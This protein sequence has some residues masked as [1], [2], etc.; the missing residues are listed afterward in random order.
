VKTSLKLIAFAP[1]VLWA[2]T[3]GV[4][5][6]SADAADFRK[7]VEKRLGK[8]SPI[9]K[10]ADICPVDTNV[11]AR[12]VF[13]D[14]GAMFI[15]DSSVRYPTHCVFA[16]EDEVSEFQK[17]IRSTSA[18]VGGRTVELQS[19]AMK[20][21]V[22]A[23]D[24]AA[25]AGLTITPRGGSA[26]KRN[27]ADTHRIW[28]SRFNPA[29]EHWIRRGKISKEAAE[30]ARNMETTD[31]VA[32]VIEWEKDE[33]WFSTGFNRSIFSSVAAPGTSQHLSMIA[34]D[35]AEF[36]N[37]DVRAILNRHGWYQTIIDDSPHFTYL[38]LKESEL[39]KR[40]LIAESR[41]GFTF[42]IPNF[43]R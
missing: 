39:S 17:S 3:G 38:G 4:V 19:A 27:Y 29:L 35:V 7:A 24:E 40:G 12:R 9:Q 30:N 13:K 36:A 32:Q 16:N 6:Q 23:R 8:A 18:T 11:V 25:K 2:L 22:G 41:G 37:K 1:I 28:L 34:L 31:Q 43:D 20:A 10:L 42:W 14:Y 26:A 5:A 33:I 15:A 21:L